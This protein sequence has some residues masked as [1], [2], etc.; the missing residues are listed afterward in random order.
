M[1]ALHVRPTIGKF[2]P[3]K[4]RHGGKA[5][6]LA[7][8]LP[9]GARALV[10]LVK[11]LERP[12]MEKPILIEGLP[13]IGFVANIAAMHMIRELG[14]RRFALIKSSSFQDFA[15]TDKDGRLRSPINELYACADRFIILYGNTQA[16][17]NVGQYELCGK[18][19][20]L[21]RG[22]GCELVITMGGYKR[23]RLPRK[24]RV[25]CAATDE[26]LLE[27]ARRLCDG[28]ILGNIY[29]A[30]GLLLG[31]GKLMGMRGVCFLAETLGLYPD[32]R[33]ASE[34]LKVVSAFLGIEI[35]LTKLE[36]AAIVA[37]DMWRSLRPP[38]ETRPPRKRGEG[39]V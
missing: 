28:I 16:N 32:P 14:G 19:L 33:A 5:Y 3:S 25:L 4:A 23:E 8:L 13:G 38:E 12:E 30:A 26:E 17:D 18:I 35:D 36:Q 21:V 39:I 27:E 34:V 6:H 11:L 29:G 2:K 22:M 1:S 10:C 7:S 37:E 20:K 9:S 24:P 15:M 31:L